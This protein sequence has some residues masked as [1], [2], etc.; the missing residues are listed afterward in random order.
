[1]AFLWR[2]IVIHPLSQSLVIFLHSLMILFHSLWI[3]K[4]TYNLNQPLQQKNLCGYDIYVRLG[5][6]AAQ[7]N[8]CHHRTSCT[9]SGTSLGHTQFLCLRNPWHISE[10]RK[11]KLL[12][13]LSQCMWQD[14][15]WIELEVN[16]YWQI[17]VFWGKEAISEKLLTNQKQS[18]TLIHKYECDCLNLEHEECYKSCN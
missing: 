13:F 1:M 5:V 4:P 14:M 7:Q 9:G 10:L 8:T 17:Q 3:H 15:E 2:Q 12:L 16:W 6:T 11:D 18:V